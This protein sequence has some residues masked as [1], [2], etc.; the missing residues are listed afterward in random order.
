MSLVAIVDGR[1]AKATQTG[2]RAICL[3][4]NCAAEMVARVGDYVV[5]HWAHQAGQSCLLDD[6]GEQGWH[7]LWRTLFV[8]AGARTEVPYDGHRADVVLADGRVVEVQT[9]FLPTDDIVSRES[10]YGDMAWVYRLYSADAHI[11][12]DNGTTLQIAHATRTAL[13][14]HQRP[15]FWQ[16]PDDRIVRIRAISNNGDRSDTGAPVWNFWCDVVADDNITFVDQ[17]AAGLNFGAAPNVL[18][19]ELPLRH[20]TERLQRNGLTAYLDEADWAA[21]EEWCDK[22]PGRRGGLRE[23]MVVGIVDTA[24]DIAENY[25]ATKPRCGVCNEPMV[26]G[27]RDTHHGCTSSQAHCTCHPNH[28]YRQWVID[29]VLPVNPHIRLPAPCPL[30]TPD[31]A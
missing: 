30:H 9:A 3:D 13:I 6:R 27:Q 7:M 16:L 17:I 10:I 21:L 22:Q 29:N 28:D 23:Q 20:R 12:S 1:P 2:Q 31:A 11:V 15:V 8:H 24:S 18:G 5:P 26:A 19:L 25:R 14:V 4:P